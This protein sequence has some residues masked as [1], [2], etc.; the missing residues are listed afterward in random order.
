[1][2][3]KLITISTLVVATLT[4]VV[5]LLISGL[6]FDEGTQSAATNLTPWLAIAL[7]VMSV[8]TFASVSVAFYLYRWRRLLIA[9]Q[10]FLVPEELG[11]HLNDVGRNLKML[12]AHMGDGMNAL[13]R[14]SVRTSEGISNLIETF[15]TLQ[16]AIDD[17]DAEIKRLKNGYDA[18]IFRRF[19]HRFIRV[20]QM[21][22]VYSTSCSENS[23]ALGQLK[24]VMED[25]LD[26]CGIESFQPN[27]GD[28]SRRTEGIADN[29]KSTKTDER[30]DDFKIAEVIEPGYRLRSGANSE[31]LIPA[32]VR[33]L[34]FEE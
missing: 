33:I 24:R 26:E 15:M 28:D 32:K 14:E 31:V 7:V 9:Q 17:R 20:D 13:G 10:K 12:S 34:L 6:D 8:T 21:I 11:K 1:M 23:E 3:W 30:D 18:E 16:K 19:V 5:Y 22:D 25:A 2:R 29:P 4:I 27:I